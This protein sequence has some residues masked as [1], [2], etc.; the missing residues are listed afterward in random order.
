MEG[1]DG[2]G[3]NGERAS[4]HPSSPRPSPLK[5]LWRDEIGIDGVGGVGLTPTKKE[6]EGVGESWG[7]RRGESVVA[8]FQCFLTALM[9]CI[10]F[11]G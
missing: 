10:S 5:F 3:L 9:P 8:I 1:R 7:V 6:E 2:A 11:V 4:R